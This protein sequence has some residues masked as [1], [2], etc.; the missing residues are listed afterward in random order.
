MKPRLFRLLVSAVAV[1]A[2]FAGPLS[3]A[4]AADYPLIASQVPLV[5][6]NYYAF[7]LVVHQRTYD[8]AAG[9]AANPRAVWI[10]TGVGGATYAQEIIDTPGFNKSRCLLRHADGSGWSGVQPFNMTLPDCTD[11]IADTAASRARSFGLYVKPWDGIYQDSLSYHPYQ[12]AVRTANGMTDIDANLDGLPD[13]QAALESAWKTGMQRYTARLQA[14]LPGKIVLANG[15]DWGNTTD[16]NGVDGNLYEQGIDYILSRQH[17]VTIQFMIDL[18]NRWYAVNTGR[19]RIYSTISYWKG[20]IDP[21]PA[22]A[23]QLMQTDPDA[24]RRMRFGLATALMAG[25]HYDFEYSSNPGS[26]GI[27]DEYRGG[28]LNKQGYLGPPLGAAVQVSPGVW[29]RDFQNGVALA[30]EGTGPATLDLSGDQLKRLKGTQA[31]AV[32]SGAAVSTVTIPSLDGIILLRNGATP[33]PVPP[34]AGTKQ[35]G[36]TTPGRSWVSAG[37]GYKFGSVFQLSDTANLVDFKWYTRGGSASQQF[38]PV[39]YGTDGAGNPAGLLAVG[40][41]VTVNAGQAA[42]WVTSALPASTLS[43]GRYLL[44]LTSGPTGSGAANAM[45]PTGTGF[46]NTNPYGAPSAAWGGLITEPATWSYYVDYTT[47]SG[48]GGGT[49]PPPPPGANLAP[50]P[51]MEQDPAG[52][53]STIGSAAFS[54]AT[55]QWRSAGHSLKIVSTQPTGTLTRWMTLPALIPVTPGK[56]YTI[57]AWVM[58][59]AAAST[60]VAGSFYNGSSFLP[61]DSSASLSGTNGW[62]QQTFTTTAPAGATQLRVEFRLYGPGALWADDLSVVAG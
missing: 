60:T 2:L 8:P 1:A 18:A 35:F 62:T 33:T 36:N 39:I 55:D 51:T 57:S 17:G 26:S 15:A 11:F 4:Q 52:S 28:D 59:S 61:A 13:S 7:D 54:W 23:A 56:R 5:T 6:G 34:P 31:P 21:L 14:N 53:Y 48:G 27:Y 24:Q 20:F 47:G 30:N 58:T 37:Q 42:G 12:Y 40:A 16:L 49:P 45:E 44:G 9:K 43:P 38:T 22:N 41:P 10:M 50:N 29:R 3:A 32:N 46:Y 19:A 25:M